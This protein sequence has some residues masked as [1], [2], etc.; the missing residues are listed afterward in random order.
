MANKVDQ[1]LAKDKILKDI[2]RIHAELRKLSQK[3]GDTTQEENKEITE[4]VNK[5]VE[6]W[7]IKTHEYLII[8]L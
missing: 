5:L 7:K 3:L 4:I 1:I 6:E 2:N 8:N